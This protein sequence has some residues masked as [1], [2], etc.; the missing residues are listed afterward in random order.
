LSNLRDAGSLYGAIIYQ[1]APVVMQQLEQLMGES[2]VQEGLRSYLQLYQ[3]DN[4]SWTDL[5]TLLDEL[6]DEDLLSWSRVWV[7]EPGRPRISVRWTGAGIELN[8]ADDNNTRALQWR[9]RVSIVLGHNNSVTE[10]FVDLEGASAF[11]ALPGITEPDFILPGS[12]GVSYGRFELDPKSRLGLLTSAATLQNPLH[13]AVAWQNLWE[14]VLDQQLSV[15]QFFDALSL[16]L[17]TETDELVAQQMLG[18]L[19]NTFW[20][21]LPENER[22]SRVQG[23]ED[24]LW[25]GL[26]NAPTA[27]QKGAW[28]N[29]IVDVTLS[30]QGLLR[31]ENIWRMNE[32]PTGLPLQEQQY[33]TLAEA[34]ALREVPQAQAILDEQQARIVNPDRLARFEFVRPA[35]SADVAKRRALFDSFAQLQN[36]RVESWVLDAQRALHH[37]LRAASSLEMLDDA[38]LL[39][40]DIQ[41]TGD[42]FFPLRWLNATLDGHRS[43][44]AAQTVRQFLAQRTDLSVP[45]R[46]KMLQASDDLFRM[47]Q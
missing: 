1:K 34:L 37:P 33:I 44:E 31:L 38:L 13:R 12:D 9:Q 23:T 18:L 29:A 22:L 17:S 8:Q 41:R 6:S 20:R 40:Q 3:F 2:A 43:N 35:F 21:F 16:A 5:I 42:I 45:L 26:Q 47:A 10:H 39:A 28:F 4:A 36:R 30:E 15:T 7:D 11:L 32:T 14:E 25:R 46:A 27:G 24:L 19:R